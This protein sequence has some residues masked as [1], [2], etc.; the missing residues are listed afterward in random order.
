MKINRHDTTQD[1][2][3]RPYSAADEYLLK[4]FLEIEHKPKEIAIYHDRFGYLTCHLQEF[5]PTIVLTNKSQQKSIE[6]NLE[7]NQLTTPTFCN[8]LSTFDHKIEW[9]LLKVPKSLALLELFLQQITQN[10]NKEIT[11]VM[12]F[13]TRHFSPKMVSIAEKYFEVVEQSRALK[14]AR[15]VTLTNKKQVAKPAIIDVI[16]YNN[17]TYQQYW[18]VFSAKHIDYATQYFLENLE[19]KPSDHTI[20][21]LASGNGVMAKAISLKLPNAKIHLLDDFYLAVESAKLNVQG[22]NV[23]HHYNNDLSIFE[24][25]TFDLIVTNPPFH[26]EYEI[27]IHIPIQLFKACFDCLKPTGCLQIVANKHLNYATHL[28]RIFPIVEVVD[29][30]DKF[31]IYRCLKRSELF[32]N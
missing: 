32:P 25:N 16:K 9:A 20:L 21:D 12:A 5:H 17:Q 3:L 26:F 27:S 19:L 30:N 18:G 28:K 22:E 15:L 6:Q 11:V 13:M 4:S 8:P 29:Q 14:K 1:Q 2:S 10:S 31:I 24:D 23:H 7:K